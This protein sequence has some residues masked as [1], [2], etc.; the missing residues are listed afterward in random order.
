MSATKYR[1]YFLLQMTAHRL[2]K[3]ADAALLATGS[4]T[5]AQAAVMTVITSEGSVSQRRIADVLALGES[6]MTP[7]VARLVKAGYVTRERSIRDNRTWQLRV[8]KQGLAALKE[9][10]A[11]F[12]QVNAM[13]DEH[14]DDGDAAKLAAALNKILYGL[15][16]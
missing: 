6:A 8:T 13:I 15:K 3:K 11:S 4:L 2:K 16:N 5:T 7:M 14:L 10:Q 1:L 9:I 12:D